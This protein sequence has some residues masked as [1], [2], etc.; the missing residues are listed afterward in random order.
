MQ[1]AMNQGIEKRRSLARVMS[2]QGICSRQE[3][4]RWIAEG[5]V[6]VEGKIAHSPDMLVP[7]NA[8]IELIGVEVPPPKRTL[9]YIVMN[10]RKGVVTTR[11]DELHRPTA[12]DD[13][14]SFLSANHITERLFAVGRLDMDTEG[15]LLFTNDNDLAHFLTD[16]HSGVPKT[17]LATLNRPITEAALQQLVAGI[18]I[19]VRGQAYTAIPQRLVQHR[20]TVLELALTEGKN[21]EVRRMFQALGY[22]VVKL[23]RIGFA[24]LR[25]DLSTEPPML[26]CQP[27][28]PGT[29]VE[30]TRADVLC[31]LG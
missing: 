25:L 11:A 16:P 19:K 8:K 4:V 24:G 15:L 22:R 5:K 23:V 29:C 27:L 6:K 14:R 26:N 17:Y 20:P 3:A 7:L 28:P 1:T 10:K 30:C 21:R 2:K 13:L 12:Y 9:R 18:A 31:G